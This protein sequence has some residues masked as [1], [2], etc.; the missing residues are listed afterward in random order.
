VTADTWVDY[1]V[2]EGDNLF[3]LFRQVGLPPQLLHR[4]LRSSKTARHLQH[5]KPG[6]RIRLHLDPRNQLTELRYHIDNIRTLQV[7]ATHTGFETTLKQAAIDRRVNAASGIVDSSLFGSAQ[8]LGLS[9]GLI[10]QMTRIFGWDIDFALE[11]RSGDQFSLIFEEHWANEKKLKEG[12]ILAAEFINGGRVHRAVRYRDRSGKIAYYAP[13]G[14]PMRK[15]FLRTPVKV[16]R[17]SSGFSLRR[18]HPVLKK[19]RAHK[20]VDYAAPKGTPVYAAGKGKVAFK[21]WKPGFGKVIFLEH[22]PKCTT[23]YGHLSDFARRVERGVRVR[24]GQL[25]GY[26]GKTGIA[27][28]PHL[29][30]EFRVNGV[31]RNP[32]SDR[33]PISYPLSKDQMAKFR[34]VAQPLLRRLDN[35]TRTLVAD[36]Q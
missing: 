30:Y 15:E 1:T 34:K 18:W 19:W 8:R 24:Q 22:G 16:S 2:Q 10:M 26:V 12:P 6:E 33:L 11:I 27:T 28:G 23:V 5:I 13:D 36:A 35:L 7:T 9:D 14:S 4:I 21:G 17:V 32:L 31:H 25:I 3:N 20:G 29:H